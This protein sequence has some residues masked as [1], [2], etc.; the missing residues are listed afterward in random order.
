MVLMTPPHRTRIETHPGSGAIMKRKPP[1]LHNIGID[2]DTQ[3][4]AGL[5]CDCPVELVNG[6]CHR[7]LSEFAFDGTEPV[8]SDPPFLLQT[9]K[10]LRRCRHDDEEA[11]HVALLALLKILT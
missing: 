4:V 10:S 11:D 1:A 2:L 7:F 5:A 3:V 9:G 8:Y 6:C